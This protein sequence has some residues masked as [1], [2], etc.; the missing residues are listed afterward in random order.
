MSDCIFCKIVSRDIPA[1]IIYEDDMVVSFKDLEPQAPVHILIVPKKHIKNLNTAI[2]ED[3]DIVSHIM[4]DVVPELAK[5]L[6]IADDGFRLVVNTGVKGGQT[7]DH[8]HF[9]LIGGRSMQW[10]PG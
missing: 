5:K 1:D 3:K 6:K 4:V 9:H 10:P 2:P 7:V 8:L